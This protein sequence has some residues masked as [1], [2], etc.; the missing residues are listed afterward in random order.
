MKN[1][2]D[3][4]SIVVETTSCIFSPISSKYKMKEV[5][6]SFH[7]SMLEQY[8]SMEFPLSQIVCKSDIQIN[9]TPTSE[10]PYPSWT[11]R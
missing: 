1:N 3:I 2:L 10:P 11:H 7:L 8:G 4:E 5:Q 6:K 9:L